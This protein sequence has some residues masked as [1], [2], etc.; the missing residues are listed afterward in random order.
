MTTPMAP[1]PVAVQRWITRATYLR[2]V[3]ALVGWLGLALVAALLLPEATWSVAMIVAAAALT[4]GVMVLGVR[5]RWRPISGY[6]GLSVSRTLRPG[7]R[8]W[9]VRA[10]RADVVV[11]TA[12]RGLRLS[13]TAPDRDAS[14]SL[15]VR[16]TRVLLV[17]LEPGAS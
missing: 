6:V 7:D 9:Y 10:D 15:S 5:V 16:R 1:A 14:E 8:A 11:V 3:D 4:A 12:R 17:P 2:W 13:V